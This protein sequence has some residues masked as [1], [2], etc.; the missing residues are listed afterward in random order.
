MADL[1]LK[2]EQYDIGGKRYTLM[3][4]MNVLAEVQ[5]VNDGNLAGALEKR[6]SLRTALQVGAAMIND[7]AEL[8]GWPERYTEKTLGRIIP[9]WELGKFSDLI[10]KLLYSAL[11]ADEETKS[12][13]ENEKN[14]E[15]SRN[16]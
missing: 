2:T 1:R 14:A 15:T 10:S 4:N 8:N 13:E 5:E 12:E 16:V 11:R 3:C 9:P 7:C 6:R